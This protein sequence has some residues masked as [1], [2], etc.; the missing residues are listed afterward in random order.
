MTQMAVVTP[1]PHQRVLGVSNGPQRIQRPVSHQKPV[2]HVS[3]AVKSTKPSDQNVNPITHVNPA[4]QPKPGSQPN[5]L[6]A[7]VAKVNLEP[8][9]PPSESAKLEKPQSKYN[10]KPDKLI[11][12]LCVS[13]CLFWMLKKSFSFLVDKPAKND[14][15]DASASKYDS[16]NI[17]IFFSYNLL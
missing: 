12:C 17:Y 5:Q 4:P 13:V 10:I 8:A 9:K 6:K 1:T 3:V 11:K 16:I 2:S 7:N 15:A 14:Y